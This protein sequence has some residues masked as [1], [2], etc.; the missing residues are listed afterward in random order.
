MTEPFIQRSFGRHAFGEDPAGYDAA[1]PAYPD[2]VFDLLRERC[3]LVSDAATFEIGAGT[4]TATRQLLAMGANPLVAVEP[5]ERLAAFL[6]ETI[7]DTRL[8]VLVAP[9][10]EAV[11]QEAGFDLGLSATAFHWLEEDA[12][13]TKVATLLRPGGWWAMLANEFGNA[14]LPDPFHEATTS[15]LGKLR[16]PAAGDGDVPFALD[17]AARFAALERTGSFDRVE[18]R[19]STWSLVLDPDQTVALYATYSNITIRQDRAD[20]LDELRRI[21][22]DEFHGCVTRNMI[23]SLYVARRRP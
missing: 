4:G 19:T 5:D 12:A 7:P 2:W 20:V 15:L 6:R 9:F 22:R 8:I 11:L 21:A 23:T 1:R 16:N 18:H 13:L 10:E 14:R 3:G 17:A